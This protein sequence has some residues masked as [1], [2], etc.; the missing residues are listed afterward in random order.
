MKYIMDICGNMHKKKLMN[1]TLH[2][3]KLNIITEK[4]AE[5]IAHYGT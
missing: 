2:Q 1:S 5:K 3:D 4:A